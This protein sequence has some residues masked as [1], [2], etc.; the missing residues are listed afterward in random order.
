M[1]NDLFLDK[2]VERLELLR[3]GDLAWQPF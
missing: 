3:E 2:L 1:S